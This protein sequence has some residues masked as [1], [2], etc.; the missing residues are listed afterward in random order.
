M[1]SSRT[2]AIA[3]AITASFACVPE[4][5]VPDLDPLARSII[6]IT[7]SETS[8]RAELFASELDPDQPSSSALTVPS[9]RRVTA[10]IY[11]RPLLDLL[12]KS[13]GGPIPLDPDGSRL[14]APEQILSISEAT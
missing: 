7:H 12:L 5:S 13:G 10:V 9:R 11:H 6:L 1:P 8:E 4:F 2:S 14:P 3:V